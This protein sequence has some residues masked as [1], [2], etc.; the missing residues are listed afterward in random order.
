MIDKTLLNQVLNDQLEEFLKQSDFIRRKVDVTPHLKSSDISVITGVRRCGKSTLLRQLSL[1][2]PNHTTLYLDLEDPR[3][4]T[5]QHSDFQ[6]CLELWEQQLQNNA[7]QN[8]LLLI[9]EV[10]NVAGWEK[11]IRFFAEKKQYKVYIT[12]SNSEMLSS[13]LGSVLGGR[14]ITLELFPFSF[15]ELI[16]QHY[17]LKHGIQHST[18]YAVALDTTFSQAL[19][20]G[21]FPKPYLEE[22]AKIYPTLFENIVIR[23]IAQRKNIRKTQ[24]LYAFALLC[25]KDNS[26]LFNLKKTAMLLQIKNQRTIAN[27][28]IYLE[29]AYLFFRL[30]PFSRSLRKTLRGGSKFYAIDPILADSICGYT[31]RKT[32]FLENLIFLQL[33]RRNEHF[34]YWL[35][36]AGYEV[37]FIRE[38]QDGEL[39]AIQ[40]C[41]DLNSSATL[42]RELRA[43]LAA[44]R[45]LSAKNLLIVTQEKVSPE[46][47]KL[48]PQHI[49]IQSFIEFIGLW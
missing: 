3:L 21:L 38:E 8:V 11:W 7:S 19:D 16:L 24:E 28:S 25:A 10:Q 6:N 13:E 47:R 36:A 42:E 40:S 29:Q 46:A 43:L 34:G 22:N 18:D 26:R 5:F 14:Y 44:E 23:D 32:V 35:S 2:Y 17:D 33:R 49:K 12:G 20:Y 4:F 30:R 27:Y 9:D 1:Q 37:D 39:T 15:E 45:E 41:Y 48:I 31:A